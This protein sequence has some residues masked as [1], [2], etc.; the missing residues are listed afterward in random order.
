MIDYRTELKKIITLVELS[1][2]EDQLNSISKFLNEKDFSGLF[3]DTIYLKSV[4]KHLIDEHW[5]QSKNTVDVLYFNSFIKPFL[6][7]ELSSVLYLHTYFTESSIDDM[8]IAI[9]S[10]AQSEKI[11]VQILKRKPA[12]FQKKVLQIALQ[13]MSDLY[14][15]EHQQNSNVKKTDE[16]AK[17]S[18][19]RSFDVLDEIFEL[20][21]LTHE[22]ALIDQKERLYEGAGV[23]VQSSYATTLLA[24]RYLNLP[25]SSTFMDLGSGYGRIGLVLGLMRPDVQFIGL[26]YVSERVDIANKTSAR[27]GMQK[28]VRFVTQDLSLSDFKIPPADTY[29]IFDAFT[30]ATYVTIMHQLQEIA[31]KKRV[32][33]VTKGNAKQ[34]MKNIC[35]TEPQEFN[36]GNLCIFRSRG[37]R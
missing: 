25:K 36:D 14:E 4:L 11:I 32:T 13:K 31:L 24:L 20:D 6:S 18:L 23:G 22:V 30:D 35:W 10:L 3:V 34:W 8:R 9:K 19:Y 29:Y 1:S 5:I 21:Y 7:A 28:H 2:L 27:Y 12:D 17:L 16:H 26:E 15:F 33:V 37:S